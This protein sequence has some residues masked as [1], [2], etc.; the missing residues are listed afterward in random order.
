MPY[1]A[2]IYNNSTQFKNPLGTI[3][4]DNSFCL[5]STFN[6]FSL[7]SSSS[8]DIIVFLLGISVFL[9]IKKN[10]QLLQFNLDEKYLSSKVNIELTD[11][12]VFSLLK[13]LT[14]FSMILSIS[15]ENFLPILI[16]LINLMSVNIEGS[17]LVYQ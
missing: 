3:I 15:L 12:I 17:Q 16:C 13:Y 6:V 9:S 11:S 7:S 2:F 5:S 8:K 4:L 1:F 10:G 14:L